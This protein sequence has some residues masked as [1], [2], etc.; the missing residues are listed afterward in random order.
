MARRLSSYQRLALAAVLT[1]CT[2]GAT[3]MCEDGGILAQLARTISAGA[4]PREPWVLSVR[5][6]AR[7]WVWH[8]AM[9]RA[10]MCRELLE[11]GY[12]TLLE[13]LDCG[14]AAAGGYEARCRG[15]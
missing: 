15:F 11:C 6:D 13:W 2:S 14:D 1:A 3:A 7:G 8:G 12:E 10:K 9:A 5:L 4:R